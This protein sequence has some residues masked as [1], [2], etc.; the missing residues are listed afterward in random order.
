MLGN[1][2]SIVLHVDI[3]ILDIRIDTFCKSI[4]LLFYRSFAASIHTH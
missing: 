1:P 2:L 3:D 4:F